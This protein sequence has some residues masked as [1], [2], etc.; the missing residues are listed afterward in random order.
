M[1]DMHQ[2][3]EEQRV[4]MRIDRIH[5]VKFIRDNYLNEMEQQEKKEAARLAAIAKK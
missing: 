2:A 5:Q 1:L 4:E 3:N